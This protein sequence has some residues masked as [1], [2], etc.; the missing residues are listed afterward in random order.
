MPDF[1]PGEENGAEVDRLNDLGINGHVEQPCGTGIDK[2]MRELQ[3][4]IR[5]MKNTSYQPLRVFTV[6]NALEK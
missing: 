1:S 4:S 5:L 2:E 3:E 6:N